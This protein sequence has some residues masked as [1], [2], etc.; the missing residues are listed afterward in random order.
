METVAHL[1]A[2]QRLYGLSLT[3]QEANYN[4]AFFGRQPGLEWDRLYEKYIPLVIPAQD[5]LSYYDLLSQFVATLRDGHSLIIPPKDLFLE[6]DRP[7]LMLM[8]IQNTPVITNASCMIAQ[9]I[10]IGSQIVKVGS[11][12]ARDYLSQSVLPLVCETTDHRLWDHAVAR[13]LLGR[14]DTKVTCTFRTPSGQAVEMELLRNRRTDGDPW[15]RSAGVPD[16]WE[17][18]YFDEWFYNQA[19]FRAFEFEILKGGIAYVAFNTFMDRSVVASFEE[20]LATIKG[21]SGLVLD[22]RKNHGGDDAIAYAIVAR[23][24]KQPTDVLV[25]RSPKHVASY[26]ATGMSMKDIEPEKVQTLDDRSRERLQCFKRQ[27]YLEEPWGNVLPAGD[28]LSLPTVILTH[29]ETGSAAEDFI[30][31]LRSGR[32]EAT[33]VGGGTAGS[34]GQ[35][36]VEDLPGGGLLAVCTIQMPW[37]DKV[38]IQGIAPDIRIE[39]TIDDVVQNKDRVL[40]AGVELISRR[41]GAHV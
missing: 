26:R 36:L 17:F 5:T 30:M 27:W 6:L 12:P 39:P 33:L 7:K 29:S 22:L 20:K 31:A 18:M 19:P 35:P 24:I 8:N 4:F 2:A 32:G 1:S 13:M 23:F 16:K 40:E 15:A 11:V 3:W 38:W 37:P 21:C 34:S 25:V 28:P 9:Q 41:H 10:P 14:K